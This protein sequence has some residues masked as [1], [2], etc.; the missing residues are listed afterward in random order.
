MKETPKLSLENEALQ[1]LVLLETGGDEADRAAF[2]TWRRAD[3]RHEAACRAARALWSAVGASSKL[4]KCAAD[5]D[6]PASTSAAAALRNTISIALSTWRSKIAA[7]AGA[8]AFVVIAA[9]IID[10]SAPRGD[11]YATGPAEIRAV[12][13]GDGSRVDLGPESRV[14]IA[15]AQDERRVTLLAGE[16]FFDVAKDAQRP[17]IVESKGAEVR[18]TGTRFNVHLGPAGVTV[19]VE[20]GA[21]LLRGAPPLLS[22]IADS[23]A[24]SGLPPERMVKAGEQRVVSRHASIDKPVK[25]VPDQ[26]GAWRSGHLFFPDN[27][28]HEL[29]ADVNR[30]STTQIIIESDK[31]GDMRIAAAFPVDN[32]D[33]M[34]DGLADLLPITIDRSRANRIVIRSRDL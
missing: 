9:A 19:A 32:I 23:V 13:L 4:G 10:V 7:A 25:V 5:L 34:L 18:V 6:R 12:A 15:Y 30:Y 24:R 29:V 26:V 8:C 21:V 27:T 22:R 17:F 3:P 14:A 28:L 33:E 20:E 31:L 16:A 11:A 1:W 2:E